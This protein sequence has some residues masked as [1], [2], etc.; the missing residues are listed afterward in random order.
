[1]ENIVAEPN[2]GGEKYL[3]AVQQL[4]VSDLAGDSSLDWHIAIPR[5]RDVGEKFKDKWTE[6]YT[7]E[8]VK[9]TKWIWTT[10]TCEEFQQMPFSLFRVNRFLFFFSTKKR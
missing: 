3:A 4:Y 10:F 1:M 8:C 2:N 6:T 5:A 7:F 9:W